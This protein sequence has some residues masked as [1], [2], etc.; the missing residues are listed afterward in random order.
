MLMSIKRQHGVGLIEV[1]VS[2]LV[3]AFAV[4]SMAGLQTLSKR[5]NREALQRSTA[6][7]LA[8]GLISRIRANAQSDALDTYVTLAAGGLGGGS[9]GNA[10]LE[11]CTAND[12]SP[13]E[14]AAYDLWQWE[15]LLDGTTEVI[16]GS[17]VNVGGLFEPIAC[18]DGPVGGV[19]GTYTLTIAWYGAISLPVDKDVACGLGLGRYGTDD[20]FRRTLAVPAFI[21]AE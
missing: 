17:A 8:D 18:L 12:C 7:Q 15:R 10:P 11:D 3:V 2:V 4:L 16:A 9:Q 20:E 14:M 6:A 21:A 1:L 19:D 13:S 5:N